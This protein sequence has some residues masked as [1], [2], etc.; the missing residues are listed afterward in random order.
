[1][2]LAIVGQRAC[3]LSACTTTPTTELTGLPLLLLPD[4]RV[5]SGTTTVLGT[6]RCRDVIVK[7]ETVVRVAGQVEW[8]L[9]SFWHIPDGWHAATTFL[10]W[11]MVFSAGFVK[12]NKTRTR[13]E[14][15][16]VAERVR[17][18]PGKGDSPASVDQIP[19]RRQ[20]AAWGMV[21]GRGPDSDRFHGGR[22]TRDA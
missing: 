8:Y 11:E 6:K 9:V 16:K 10:Y 18:V 15:E 20:S 3:G 21:G 2:A 5:T 7:L 1:M 12:L 13:Q 4:C 14:Q 22:Q 17:N 19:W